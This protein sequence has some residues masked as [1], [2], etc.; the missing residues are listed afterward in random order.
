MDTKAKSVPD[1]ARAMRVQ[2]VCFTR[3]PWQ[4][5]VRVF[6][7]ANRT[8]LKKGTDLVEYAGVTGTKHIT[9]GGER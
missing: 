3:A 9:A 4:V 6:F 5:V 2:G 8:A 7:L 1:G